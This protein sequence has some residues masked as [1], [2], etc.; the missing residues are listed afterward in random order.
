M[1]FRNPEKRKTDFREV[2]LGL[3][4]RQA[5][6]EAGRCLQCKKPRCVAGCPVEIDIPQFISFVKEKDYPGGLKKI[7]EFNML[8]AICGRVCPQETQCQG[9]CI[10]GKKS[11]PV[12]IG[13]IERFVADYAAASGQIEL[14]DM[15]S[16]NSHKVAVIGSGPA[17]LTV[18]ADLAKWGYDITVFEA[19]HEPGGVLTYGIPEFR[20][21]KKIIQRE[22]EFVKNLG[23]KIRLNFLIGRTQ[24]VEE[25]FDEGYKAIFIGVGAGSPKFMGIPGENLNNVYFAS[26]FLTRVNL[27]K[28]HKFPVYDTPVKKAKNVAVIGGG[29]VAMDSARTA[30]RLGAERVFI[31]YRRTEKEMPSRHEEVE[32][33]KEE[34]I[35]FCF[36][37][38][39]KE[40]LGDEKGRVQALKCDRM[41]LGEP[42]ESGRRRPKRTGEDFILDVEQVIM[43]IGQTSNPILVRSIKRLK[44]W[45]EGYIKID[46]DGRT[47]LKGIFAGGDISTGAATVISAMGAGKRA[48]RA[49]D[50]F[51]MGKKGVS[52]RETG[53]G[54][55]KG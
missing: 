50:D 52:T 40:I 25:L 33:A 37:S 43:A 48:A 23:V 47:N 20:L 41:A 46:R 38:N 27:M 49:I 19:L 16:P 22:I 55:S 26:E 32:N 21:P 4:Q 30:L 31:V 29:N 13:A 10:L 34:G 42:D 15:K 36:L 3:T 2:S 7:R 11:G 5:V 39:P 53:G 44:L 6:E 51:I 17:G 54:L 45:G 24:T 35:E 8:P 14:P 1:R 9:K 18:A 28:A 12:S